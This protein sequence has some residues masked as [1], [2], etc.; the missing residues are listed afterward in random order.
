MNVDAN[1]H[2]GQR[3]PVMCART[4]STSDVSCD[5]GRV[6]ANHRHCI[7][8]EMREGERFIVECFISS[9]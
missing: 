2:P 8:S 4:L 5:V 7:A 3:D 9:L 1:Y 6:S